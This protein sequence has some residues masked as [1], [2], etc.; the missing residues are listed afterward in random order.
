MRLGLP[1]TVTGLERDRGHK[2]H[3][4]LVGLCEGK[5]RKQRGLK[6]WVLVT[7]T[8]PG[9]TKLLALYEY[10]KINIVSLFS[11]KS[12]IS[13]FDFFCGSPV[14]LGCFL[15][16]TRTNL[17]LKMS[18]VIPIIKVAHTLYIKF[19]KYRERWQT[20]S[21]LKSPQILSIRQPAERL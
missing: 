5:G 19:G 21:A 8:F 18:L 12:L 7:R 9:N 11:K 13:V 17:F 2:K 1:V 15:N 14:V 16:I 3:W 20:E 4:V 6:F 10:I